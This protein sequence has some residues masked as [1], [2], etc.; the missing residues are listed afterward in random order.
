LAI[1]HVD[2]PGLA[3]SAAPIA[4]EEEKEKEEEEEEWVSMTAA[5]GLG[6]EAEVTMPVSPITTSQPI[7]MA[8][9]I[10]EASGPP[11][12][13]P[14]P[15][16][17]V[18]V[19]Y[20]PI[21]EAI[22]EAPAIGEVPPIVEA[23][24]IGEA[25]VQPPP[26]SPLRSPMGM[27]DGPGQEEDGEEVAVL[28]PI[29]SPAPSPARLTPEEPLPPVALSPVASPLPQVEV[30]EGEGEADVS[31]SVPLS[32]PSTLEPSE[33]GE[34]DPPRQ[35]TPEADVAAG[36]AAEEDEGRLASPVPVDRA[37]SSDALPDGAG[38]EEEEEEEDD[39]GDFSAPSPP[40]PPVPSEEGGV[41]RE[42]K[43]GMEQVTAPAV[44]S[45]RQVRPY[46]S[47]WCIYHCMY[48]STL[49]I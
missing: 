38:E 33:G 48:A 40:P 21:V 3:T 12:A 28:S 7:T 10:V 9:P 22:V 36:L 2:L 16:L 6:G 45:P 31:A 39:F 49:L 18:E 23:P 27:T 19:Q 14:S 8:Q 5:E 43:E 26:T 4:E 46:P 1:D 25:P 37:A 47:G 34:I 29:L 42:G 11:L 24:S 15:E 17:P 41:D 35:L 20:T 44:D 13:E 30:G 32:P